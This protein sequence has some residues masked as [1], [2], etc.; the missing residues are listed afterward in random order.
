MMKSICSL[1]AALVLVAASAHAADLMLGVGHS[2]IVNIPG[3][4]EESTVEYSGSVEIS[5]VGDGWV[6]IHATEP[7]AGRIEA[8]TPQGIQEYSVRV[9]ST[10]PDDAVEQL[11][12]LFEDIEARLDVR[13][14]GGRVFVEGT[15]KTQADKLKFDKVMRM[16]PD[17]VD[18]VRVE[19]KQVLVEVSATLI[20]VQVSSG[21]D[22]MVLDPDRVPFRAGA[23]Y[24]WAKSWDYTEDPARRVLKWNVGIDEELLKWVRAMIDKGKAR[25]VAR[26]SVVTING[27]RACLLSG[28]EIPYTTSNRWIIGSTRFKPYGV[29]LD[30]TPELLPSGE[31]MMDLVVESSEPAGSGITARRATVRSAVDKG[32]SLL[33]AGLSSTSHVS[34]RGFGC[35]FPLFKS[36]SSYRRKEL[37]VLVTPNA[38][39]VLGFDKFDLIKEEDLD[40]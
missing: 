1:L 11:V 25:V 36:G 31:V 33:L 17:V 3:L 6:R 24:D 29:R 34:G 38:P 16:F 4:T 13:K 39:S 15:I 37:L 23:S 7:G 40:R 27:Q 35:L 5:E 22:V 26:P 20:E 14:V 9:V 18:M 12:M 19:A 30:V 21:H 10:D 8:E 28:G 32:Q 2:T